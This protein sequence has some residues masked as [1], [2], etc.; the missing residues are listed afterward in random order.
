MDTGKGTSTLI[1]PLT[2]T[3]TVA[4]ILNGW[5]KGGMKG[6]RVFPGIAGRI[7]QSSGSAAV[8]LC[9]DEFIGFCKMPFTSIDSFDILPFSSS[10]SS[11]T[12]F[13]FSFPFSFS[14][15]FSFCLSVRLSRLADKPLPA[16]GSKTTPLC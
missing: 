11:S 6:Y 10:F 13:P 3:A 2:G 5:V 4:G 12:S 1:W 9:S 16:L 14:I 15:N 8:S 7:E